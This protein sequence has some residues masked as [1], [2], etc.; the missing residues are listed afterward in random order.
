MPT[1]IYLVRPLGR[2]EEYPSDETHMSRF[3]DFRD[4]N[5]HDFE[6]GRDHGSDWN[7]I[8]RPGARTG[9]A[10]EAY[11]AGYEFGGTCM[12]SYYEEY[13]D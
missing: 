2:V 9:R 5:F 4:P 8:P 6:A 12:Q 1:S 11:L 3:D 7:P 13:P 10:L